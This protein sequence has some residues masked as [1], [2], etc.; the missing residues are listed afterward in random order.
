MDP[1]KVLQSKIRIMDDVWY[2][3][4][5]NIKHKEKVIIYFIKLVN[6]KMLFKI[7]RKKDVGK[8]EA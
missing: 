5:G 8:V 4:K 3:W 2:S 6:P 1:L 7:K